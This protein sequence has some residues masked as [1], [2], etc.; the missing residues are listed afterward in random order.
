LKGEVKREREK[1]LSILH[2]HSLY[3][4]P[5]LPFP[6]IIIITYSFT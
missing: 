5:L 4:L 1:T 6:R 3:F 2:T